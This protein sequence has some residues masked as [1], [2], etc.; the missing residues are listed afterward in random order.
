MSEKDIV[1]NLENELGG[2]KNKI[3]PVN[4]STGGGKAFK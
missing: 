4:K 3:M 1:D 2:Y